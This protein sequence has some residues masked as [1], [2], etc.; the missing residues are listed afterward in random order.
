MSETLTYGLNSGGFVRMRLPEIR[1]AILDDLKASFGIDFDETPDSFTG[2][3]INIFAEREA[4]LWELAERGF[5]A[6]FPVAAQGSLLD[7]SVSFSGVK[8]LLPARSRAIGYFTGD[9]GAI[10]PAGTVIQA[11]VATDA[12]D[13]PPRFVVQADVAL[14]KSAAIAVSLTIPSPVVAGMIYWIDINGVRYNVTAVQNQTTEQIAAALDNQIGNDANVNGSIINLNRAEN[15]SVDWSNTITLNNIT[16]QGVLLAEAFGAIPAAERTITRIITPVDGLSAVTNPYAAVPGRNLETDDELRARYSLGVFRLGAGTLP[17]IHA[18]I[19]QD[20]P[21]I[22]SLRVFE[23]NTDTT[24]ADGRPGHSIEVVADGGDT[25]AIIEKI[26]QVKAAGITAYGNTTG[27]VRSQDG[28]LHP[29]RFSRP[30]IRWVWIRL[31]YGTNQEE[32]IP[33]NIEG[34]IVESIVNAGN[35]LTPGQDVIRQRLEAAPFGNVPGVNRISILLAV[36]AP[37]AVAPTSYQAVDFAM[38]PRQKA[39]FDVSR[40]QIS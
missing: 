34:L 1:R 32:K 33:G 36:T 10:V 40:V 22:K 19:L 26:Y 30:E 31:V 28:Y 12:A 25:Q 16:C 7:A 11:T 29:I 37:N 15:F 27:V 14:T 35:A 18:N 21:G 9:T 4:A 20:V 6:P 3:F 17:S 13:V 2:Q 5:F 23:N 38:N 39:A 24:D 8:R